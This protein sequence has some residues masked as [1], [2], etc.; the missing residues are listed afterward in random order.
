MATT[1]RV[2]AGLGRD[3]VQPRAKRSALTGAPSER[4][5]GIRE[6][7]VMRAR[8]RLASGFYDRTAVLDLAVRRLLRALTR[9]E[10]PRG[11]RGWP[12]AEP[13]RADDGVPTVG[14]GAAQ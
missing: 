9:G 12:G 3:R 7:L 8:H 10:R 11:L 13:V 1:A 6:A 2:D 4:V 5:R 14:R